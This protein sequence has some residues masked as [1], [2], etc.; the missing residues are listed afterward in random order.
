M[1]YYFICFILAI[2]IS[3]Y[4]AQNPPIVE[5][6]GLQENWLYIS[7]DTNFIK[8]QGDPYSSPY[9][10]QFPITL[11]S[12][13]NDLYI[14]ELSISQSPYTG[15]EGCLLHK[16]E[17]S[18]G[19]NKWTFFNNTYIGNVHRESYTK[20]SIY[21]NSRGNIELLGYR[22]LDTID[23]TMPQWFGFYSKPIKRIL[24]SGTGRIINEV[25]SPDS[26]RARH[27]HVGSGLNTNL[28]LTDNIYY[29][30]STNFENSTGEL[31]NSLEFYPIDEMLSVDTVPIAKINYNTGLDLA[32]AESIFPRSI[33]LSGDTIVTLF[34]KKDTTF[35]TLIPYELVLQWYDLSDL[36]DLQPLKEINLKN[37]LYSPQHPNNEPVQLIEKDDQIFLFQEC[38]GAKPERHSFMWIAWFNRSGQLLGKVEKFGF[39][40]DKY[41][42]TI[43]PLGTKNSDAYFIGQRDDFNYDVLKLEPNTNQPI[44]TGEINISNSTQLSKAF[45]I[46]GLFLPNE[47]LLVALI[48]HKLNQ[49]N[50]EDR[51]TYYL[52]FSTNDLGIYTS[53]NPFH[54]QDQT[55]SISPNPANDY[56]RVNPKQILPDGKFGIFTMTG[57]SVYTGN[58]SLKAPFEINV[59]SLSPGT[60]M[61]RYH[62]S[63]NGES[64]HTLFVKM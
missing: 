62:S 34:G 27:T 13:K 19:L 41:Y 52:N 12:D 35:N 26:V 47:S 61:L 30:V 2:S 40:N 57:Q 10:G 37:Q 33:Q 4:N 22:D 48:I 24:D 46:D 18:T 32:P 58:T 53:T 42:E 5:F 11:M 39:D 60:Y 31:I 51:F 49:Q 64:Y 9:W 1:Q 29:R 6:N 28:T 59:S 3:N 17:A 16:I 45:I 21:K 56:I 25:I 8:S 54:R 14:F 43:I 55:L 36:S 20:N 50:V 23:F 7:E 44:K 38:Q 15:F 63:H